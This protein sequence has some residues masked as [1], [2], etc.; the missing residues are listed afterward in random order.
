MEGGGSAPYDCHCA[1]HF[2]TRHMQI[3]KDDVKNFSSTSDIC[4]MEEVHTY[5]MFKLRNGI[6]KYVMFAE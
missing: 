6:C 4:F 5:I 3:Y 2:V 1:P